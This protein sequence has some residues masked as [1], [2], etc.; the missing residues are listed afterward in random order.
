MPPPP[1]PPPI[2]IGILGMPPP[3][4]PGACGMGAAF[5][6]PPSPS[7]AEVAIAFGTEPCQVGGTDIAPTKCAL[8]KSPAIPA[9]SP[10]TPPSGFTS[11]TNFGA[12]TSPAAA[13]PA[14]AAAPPLAPCIN[15][16]I[17]DIIMLIGMAPI[18]ATA[19]I[20]CRGADATADCTPITKPGTTS[21]TPC[22]TRATPAEIPPAN[23][24]I[25]AP[26]CVAKPAKSTGGM[27]KGVKVEATDVAPVKYPSI[28]P[29]SCAHIS[30]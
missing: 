25:C 11:P 22:A 5:G 23:P 30:M 16:I 13:V 24:E 1:P 18:C 7:I 10:P 8:P 6:M 2:G 19:M 4:A 28:A 21:T 15:D 9:P 29:T 17:G 20:C 27:L 3:E 26:T 14:M 12:S